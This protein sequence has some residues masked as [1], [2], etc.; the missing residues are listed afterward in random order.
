MINIRHIIS[1]TVDDP[2]SS[3]LNSFD[4]VNLCFRQQVIPN[5]GSVFQH[6]PDYPS[7][8]MKQVGL[9]HISQGHPYRQ[10]NAM[11]L[12]KSQQSWTWTACFT[13]HM[14]L[15]YQH[16]RTRQRPLSR[17]NASSADLWFS[18]NISHEQRIQSD[19]NGLVIPYF[20]PE[21]NI[22]TTHNTLTSILVYN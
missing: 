15:C 17:T 13:Y 18:R 22:T 8:K 11:K 5:W 1:V 12:M 20:R 19:Y 2:K 7:V 14:P 9:S 21:H 16:H 4:L 3:S 6:R 10:L